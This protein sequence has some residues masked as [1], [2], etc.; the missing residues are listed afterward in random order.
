MQKHIAIELSHKVA[1]SISIF[2]D[3]YRFNS[4]LKKIFDGFCMQGAFWD[5]YLHYWK[6]FRKKKIL[7]HLSIHTHWLF[8]FF[9]LI[10]MKSL[11]NFDD[12]LFKS[13]SVRVINLGGMN[14]H[15]SIVQCP[16][17]GR[18]WILILLY[19]T[20]S[21]RWFIEGINEIVTMTGH[22]VHTPFKNVH[23]SSAYWF[24]YWKFLSL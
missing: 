12:I 14:M 7:K 1:Q 19:S 22:Y 23:K 5:L 6:V 11:I 2:I 9:F 21:R 10:T 8:F 13:S 20:Y 17:N 16:D 3:K 24:W 15:V 4:I 18:Q